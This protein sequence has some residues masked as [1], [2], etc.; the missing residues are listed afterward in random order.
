[1]DSSSRKIGNRRKAAKV[2]WVSL[3]K[4]LSKRRTKLWEVDVSG[5]ESVPAQKAQRTCEELN[6]LSWL[7]AN[8][9]P[10]KP[11]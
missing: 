9:T 4:L 11:P 7:L 8:L 3:K 6:F 2:I 1:M 5:A 10:L